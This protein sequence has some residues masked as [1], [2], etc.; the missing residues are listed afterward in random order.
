MN[1]KFKEI[2][3]KSAFQKTWAYHHNGHQI[4]VKNWWS[5][6]GM[7]GE[8]YHL[9]GRLMGENFYWLLSVKTQY[10]FPIDNVGL[11]KVVIGTKWYGTPGCHIY[12][13]DEL[14][15]GDIDCHLTP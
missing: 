11:C 14:V 5:I 6:L 12:I 4:E 9:N 8:S 13:N 3:R 7:N 10:L 15:G 1:N 2:V